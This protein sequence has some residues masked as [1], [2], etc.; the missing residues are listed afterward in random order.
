MG[1]GYSDRLHECGDIVGEHLRR[2]HAGRLIRLSG[3]A[4]IDRDAGEVLR[5]VRD[6]ERVTRVIGR[7]VWDEH[8]GLTAPLLVVIHRDVAGSNLGHGFLLT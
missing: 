4:Q 6:L 5:V 2:V 1:L 3:P 8:E 7:K